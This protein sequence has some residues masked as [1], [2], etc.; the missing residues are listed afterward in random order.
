VLYFGIGRTVLSPR[1]A[2]V[3]FAPQPLIG[4]AIMVAAAALL[5]AALRVF[6]SWRLL[7]RIEEGHRLCRIGPF[8]FLRH[9]IYA[10]MDLVAL[11]SFA[12]APSP[13]VLAGALL[14]IAGG[15]VRARAEEKLL[16]SVF[17]DEYRAYCRG[18]A[19][20]VPGLY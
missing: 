8:R 18:T 6:Q 11:G 4:G 14:V 3:L 20:L 9:P 15:D 2:P 12:W 16:V 10:A 17:G 7:A 1:G 13:I 19:R 5:V